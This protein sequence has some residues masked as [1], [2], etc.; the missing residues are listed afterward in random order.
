MP[1]APFPGAEDGSVAARHRPP[2]H[3]RGTSLLLAYLEDGSVAAR[4]R[5]P[6]HTRGTSL[7]LAYLLLV[8]FIYYI[9][10]F[11]MFCYLYSYESLELRESR[12]R[13]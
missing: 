10:L 5:P 6:A 11:N 2:A 13:A 7:L 12:L 3:T 8:N 9:F 1:C 4:H